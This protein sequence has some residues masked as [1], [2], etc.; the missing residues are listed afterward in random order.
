MSTDDTAAPEAA[1]FQAVRRWGVVRGPE[2]ILGGVISGAGS[3]V[4]L[5]PWPARLIVIVV[6]FF[7]FPVVMLAYAFGWAVLPDAEGRIVIQDFGR[8]VTNVGALIG[9]AIFG[10]VGIASFS[11][12]RPWGRNWVNVDPGSFDVAAVAR[13]LAILLALVLPFLVLFGIVALV[14]FISRRSSSSSADRR[15]DGTEPVYAL[16]PQQARAAASSG[17]PYTTTAP[18]PAQ[19]AGGVAKPTTPQAPRTPPPT[20]ATARPRPPR[21]PGPGAGFH[22]TV[23]AWA[24]ISA[25]GT[26]W[27]SRE[28]LLAIYSPLAWG[29]VFLTGL[30]VILIMVS[31]SGRKLGFLGF[32]GALGMFPALLLLWWHP[33]LLDSYRDDKPAVDFT[34]TEVFDI[35]HAVDPTINFAEDYQTVVFT[36]ECWDEPG[37]VADTT[38]GTARITVP[39]PVTEDATFPMVAATTTVTV[40]QGTSVRVVSDGWAQAIVHFADRDLTCNYPGE[41]G[42]YV[43]LTNPGDPVITLSV[44]DDAYANT[45]VIEEK[46]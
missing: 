14:I 30:G 32:L 36:G 43:T 22:L 33:Q 19:A 20:P 9:I 1:F 45:I 28:G 6:G 18:S 37:F 41:E 46:K 11:D 35:P 10:V 23:L 7:L 38:S 21:V 42:D 25:A 44:S 15:T 40:P 31:L 29:M 12:A 16:T 27:A 24:L 3:R 39:G 13:A 26:A 5:A 34:V 17:G 8:G 2:G 4:G